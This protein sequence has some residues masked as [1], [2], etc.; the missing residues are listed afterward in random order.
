MAKAQ[1]KERY[2]AGQLARTL[3][4]SLRT[5]YRW[6]ES[7]VIPRADRIERG[8]VS[9][10][11]YTASQVEEIRRKVQARLDFT[12]S[13]WERQPEPSPVMRAIEQYILDSGIGIPVPEEYRQIFAKAAEFARNHGCTSITV[14]SP[15]SKQR[16]FSL[17]RKKAVIGR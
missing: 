11:I 10:R 15:D 14:A 3:G 17:R 12:G 8:N 13:L 9:T 7:G 2:T 6:E 4:C 1:I 16:K 5:L